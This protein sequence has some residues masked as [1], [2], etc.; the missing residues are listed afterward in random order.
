M[1]GVREL[2]RRTRGVQNIRKITKAIELVAGT[3]LRRLQERAASTR[4]FAARLGEI[5]QRVAAYA[6]PAPRR[7]SWP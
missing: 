1:K 7:R 6:D 3:K 2:K 5:M 4:P